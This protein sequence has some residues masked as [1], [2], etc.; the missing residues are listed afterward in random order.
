MV[1]NSTNIYQQSTISQLISLGQTQ[2]SGI[3]KPADGN[4]TLL[5][6]IYIASMAVFE[7]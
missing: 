2:Q 7:D 4:P 5:I 6:T 3:V 1:N